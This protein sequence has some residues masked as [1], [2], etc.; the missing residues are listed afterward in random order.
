ME[1]RRFRLRRADRRAVPRERAPA[2]QLRQ[3]ARAPARPSR[4]ASPAP[5]A[6]RPSYPKL[7]SPLTGKPIDE[8]L[9][10]PEPRAAPSS[11]ARGSPTARTAHPARRGDRRAPASERAS[12][13]RPRFRPA[14]I[15]LVDVRRRALLT[16]AAAGAADRR[17]RSSRSPPRRCCASPG[18]AW[19][20]RRRPS[21]RWPTRCCRRAARSPTATACRW[22]ARSRPMRC[23]STRRRWTTAARRW[24]RP[25]EEVAAAAQGDL[26]RPRRSR[27]RPP[28]R[29]RASP[30]T[31]AAAC[32]PRTP[33]RSTRSA[34]SRSSCR[35]RPTGTI[36]K[37]RWPRTCSA[38]STRTATATSAWKPR[39]TSGCAIRR[40]AA[41]PVALS[42]DVRVQGALE[43]ELR[44]GMLAVDAV[45][46]AG[47]V[48]DV[49]TGEVLALASLPEFDPEQDR[50][51]RAEAH[52]Q[53]GDQ[54]GLRAR[55]DLQAADRRR[56][57]RRRRR[58]R[59][60]RAAIR[61]RRSTIGGFTINDSHDL[62]ASL[63]VPEMLIHSSNIVTAQV[64]DELGAA[65]LKQVMADLGMNE[66]P[67]IE[68]PARGFPIWAQRRLA[69]P[70]GR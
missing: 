5:A 21:V 36:R 63:N 58:H 70:A 52:V 59:P 49:D 26:P 46:A 9:V 34:S 54:P 30:A 11:P 37:A 8:E 66:R 29:R 13:S 19:S 53:P 2:G 17:R 69:A 45:G 22:R 57:D 35:A 14:R 3:P 32:C 41:S 20:S 12:R 25:P 6:R 39:S 23:G 47:I 44:R 33:T 62:G 27:D 55:L 42:I 67:Y 40:A 56:G 4:S 50:R 7:V 18:S 28:A 24:S 64:V 51:R 61:P 60:R 48:L 16:R 38:T 43:D 10:E 31:C 65:R 15:R 68:L 1:P